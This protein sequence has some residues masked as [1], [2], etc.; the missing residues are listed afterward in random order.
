MKRNCNKTT[1]EQIISSILKADEKTLAIYI[2]GS[3]TNGTP[4]ENSD[5]DICVIMPDEILFHYDEFVDKINENLSVYPTFNIKTHILVEHKTDFNIR[6]QLPTIAK[7]IY[8]QGVSIYGN[9][10]LENISDIDT[11]RKEYI[12]QMFCRIDNRIRMLNN[13]PKKTSAKD[14]VICAYRI[15]MDSLRV[16][17]IYATKAMEKPKYSNIPDKLLA[18]CVSFDVKF[19]ILTKPCD[20]ISQLYKNIDQNDLIT[21]NQS[22]QVRKYTIDIRNLLPIIEVSNAVKYNEFIVF[23]PK[24]LD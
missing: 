12:I 21:D 23:D 17:V 4:N 16:F 22:L 5:I 6:A 14:I 19:A 20:Y 9:F 15:M 3:Y 11:M 7:V 2:F 13:Y 24:Y 18:E 8:K 10:I 1:Q